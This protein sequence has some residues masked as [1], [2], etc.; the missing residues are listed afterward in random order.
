MDLFIEAPQD[1][2]GWRLRE[3]QVREQ[4][5]RERAGR[6]DCAR[7]GNPSGPVCHKG[8]RNRSEP[9]FCGDLGRGRAPRT[10]AAA[11]RGGYSLEQETYRKELAFDRRRARV[12]RLRCAVRTLALAVAIPVVLLLVF[13]ASYLLTCMLNGA[14]PEECP[15]L[16][17]SLGTRIVEFAGSFC[18]V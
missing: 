11:P 6:E 12:R 10:T 13:I 7:P 8:R 1:T 17:Q 3:L 4:R 14:A 9:G 18:A 5:I 2:A 16:L 15:Q